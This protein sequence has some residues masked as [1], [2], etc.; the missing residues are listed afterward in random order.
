MARS[1]ALVCVYVSLFCGS[2]LGAQPQDSAPQESEISSPSQQLAS[3][4]DEVWEDGLR[5]F[6]QMATISGDHRFNDKLASISLA[7]A[8][9]RIEKTKVFH[10]RLEAITTE[11]LSGNEQIER[12]LLLR[13]LAESIT[14]YEF[15]EYLMPISGRTGFHIYFPE[16]ADDVPLKTI[17]DYENYIARLLAFGDYTDGYIEIM[18]EGIR[19]GVTQ[20]AVILEGINDVVG[21]HIVED[22]KQSLLY[23]PMN[24][25]PESFS[26]AER[27]RLDKEMIKAIEEVVVPAFDR[28]LKF[29]N[30]EYVPNCRASIGA[31][32][33]P[34]GRDYY[35]YRVR[36]FTTLDLTPEQVHERGL[37]EVKRIRGEMMEII[38]EVEFDG[39][40]AA[41]VDYLREE[42]K[43]YAKTKEELLGEASRILKK[44]DGEMPRLFGLLP[45]L[46]YG[47]KEIPDYIAPQTTS[48]Y[49]QRPTGD[50][51]RAGFFFLNTYNLP[52]RPLYMLEALSL[53]EA[54]PG[55]HHQLA[56]Q[57][58]L[59]GLSP[60]RRNG[61]FT[62][63]IEGW[64]LYAE[65]LGLEVGF[66][67]D[68]YSDFGRLSME[69]W[70]A[71]RLVVDTGIHYFGWS[72]EEAIAFMKNNSAMSDHNIRAEIDRYIGWP[73]QALAYK[74]GELKIRELRVRC[75]AKLGDKFD[76][77]AFHDA[78]LRNGSVPL[79]VLERLI[80]EWL[81]EQLATAE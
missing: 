42:P 66:Y 41:F 8:K 43:F 34:E 31:L 47:L 80:N 54:V 49:Y 7:D 73:G 3:L 44:V 75:E 20:P 16:L 71:C 27:E 72:R 57:Q 35:R 11:G 46:P 14:E 10:Q 74:T 30:D 77:R 40:F 33:L 2:Q 58:E 64:A 24:N 21:P 5:E 60:H 53:H 68:P 59:E 18:R 45:R 19:Q 25:V 50:G 15:K 67:E 52:G 61:G 26:D 4:L 29:L 12:D 38:K 9:R 51:T 70:R 78:V 28:F 32:A 63:F 39:D 62:A 6:P 81:D 56:L 69:M 36:K 13:Q 17:K 79:D 37:E 48:A 55:H 65:R 1:L 76:I 22:P 23:K